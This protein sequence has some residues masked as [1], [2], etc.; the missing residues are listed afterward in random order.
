MLGGQIGGTDSNN[1]IA[2][3]LLKIKSLISVDI[4][5]YVYMFFACHTI[6]FE[7]YVVWYLQIHRIAFLICDEKLFLWH[8]KISRQDNI[9]Q[10]IVSWPYSYRTSQY[11]FRDNNLLIPTYIEIL[12]ATLHLWTRSKWHLLCKPQNLKVI[13]FWISHHFINRRCCH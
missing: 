10:D 4:R 3:R 9:W 1:V 2:C 11:P 7:K 8:L 13:K 12:Y 5:K 6:I